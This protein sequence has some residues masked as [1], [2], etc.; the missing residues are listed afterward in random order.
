MAQRPNSGS[1]R[2]IVLETSL[3]YTIHLLPQVKEEVKDA[4]YV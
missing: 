2:D 1:N 3:Y 4:I